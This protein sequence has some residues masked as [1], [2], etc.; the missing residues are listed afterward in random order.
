M[1]PSLSDF[2][3]S[4]TFELYDGNAKGAAEFPILEALDAGIFP[5]F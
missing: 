1:G 5:D 3:L 4:L 2:R